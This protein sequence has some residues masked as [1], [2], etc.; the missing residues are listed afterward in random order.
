MGRDGLVGIDSFD[1][2]LDLVIA[3]D[4]QLAVEGRGRARRTDRSAGL[5]VRGDGGRRSGPTARRVVKEVEAGGFPFDGT[6]CDFEPDSTPAAPAL[7]SDGLGDGPRVLETEL[8]L[9][10]GLHRPHDP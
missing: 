7:P 8:T 2:A 4:R 10:P 6:W 3:P 1:H 5:L 9:V